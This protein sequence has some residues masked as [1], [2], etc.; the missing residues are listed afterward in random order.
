MLKHRHQNIHWRY[1]LTREQYD[2]MLADQHGLC[3]ICGCPPT[4]TVKD[5]HLHVDHLHGTRTV[6][7]LLCL[8]CNHLIGK[9][10]DSPALLDAAKAYLLRHRSEMLQETHTA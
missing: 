8:G 7:G 3:A 9:A 4:G 1:G 6:R 2:A 10:K 5:R